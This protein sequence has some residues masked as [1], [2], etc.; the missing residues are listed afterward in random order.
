M[1]AKWVENE[2]GRVSIATYTREDMY[3]RPCVQDIYD[4][5]PEFNDPIQ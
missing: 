4:N 3:M 2:N 5:L 1:E